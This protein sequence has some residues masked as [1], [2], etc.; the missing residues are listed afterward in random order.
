MFEDVESS[1]H[2]DVGGRSGREVVGG[3]GVLDESSCCWSVDG[4]FT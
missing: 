4:E 1:L 2:A 3:E